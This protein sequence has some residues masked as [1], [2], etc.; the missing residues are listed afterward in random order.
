M[1]NFVILTSD[2]KTWRSATEDVDIMP[3]VILNMHG[4]WA[5]DS[6]GKMW[7]LA[8]NQIVAVHERNDG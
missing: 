4:I 2:G 5:A 6:Q 7:R 8:P 3:T 1:R